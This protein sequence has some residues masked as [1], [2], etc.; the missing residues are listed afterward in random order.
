MDKYFEYE[1]VEDNKKVKFI[2]TRFKGHVSLWWDSIQDDR[3][4]RGKQKIT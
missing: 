3:R 1:E 2:V 4:K